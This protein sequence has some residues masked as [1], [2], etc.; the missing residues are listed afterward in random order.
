MRAI[1]IVGPIAAYSL[2]VYIGEETACAMVGQGGEEPMARH[3]GHLV[4]GQLQE[5]VAGLDFIVLEDIVT[6]SIGET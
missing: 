5:T 1:E 6:E 4:A 2:K 3:A